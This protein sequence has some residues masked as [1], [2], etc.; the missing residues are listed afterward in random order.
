MAEV[1]NPYNVMSQDERLRQGSNGFALPQDD[2]EIEIAPEENSKYEEGVR[3]TE[4]EDGSVLIDLSPRPDFVPSDDFDANLAEEL[5]DST[6]TQIASQLLEGIRR[7]DDSRQEWLSNYRNGMEL[8]GLKVKPANADP[9]ASGAPLEGMSNV[10]HP[11]L[12]ENVMAFQAAARGELLP[13]AGPVK[14]RDD[15]PS[16]PP[17]LPLATPPLPVGAPPSP[18]PPGM[19]APSAGPDALNPPSSEMSGPAPIQAG[20]PPPPQMPPMAAPQP[21]EMPR[22]QLA[23]AF[24]K[25]FNHYLT[26]TA[27]EYYPDTDQMFFTV[28]FG[29][30]GIKK[31]INCPIRRRPVSESVPIEDFIVSNALND[32][33]NAQ[34]ITHAI[35]MKPSTLR[36]M[37]LLGVYRNIELGSPVGENNTN[38]VTQLKADISGVKINTN[39]P[40]DAEYNLYETLCELDIPGYEH[41][42]RKGKVTGLKLPYRVVI[43]KESEKIL[44]IRRNWKEDDP[45]CIAK[46]YYAEYYYDKAF[47]FYGI[48]L[49]NLLGNTTKALTAVW[50]EFIDSGMF[51]NF[52]GM[53][54]NKGLGRQMTNQF[55]VPPG[56]GIGLD[57]GLQSI[58]DAIM[59]LPYKDLGPAFAAFIQRVEELG[60][61]LGGT[62]NMNVAEGKQDAPVGTT[63]ALIEQQTKAIGAVMKRLHASQAREFALLKERFRDDPSAFWRFNPRPARKWDKEAF[64][65]ALNDYDLVPV[66]DPNNPTAMHRSAKA[67]AIAQY[68]MTAPGVLDPKKVWLRVAR[69][70]EV[71]SPEDLLMP[72]PPPGA[73]PPPDPTKMAELQVKTSIEGM[74]QQNTMTKHQTDAQFKA[75]ELQDREREREHEMQLAI[76]AQN[77]EKLRLASN[78]AM[79]ADKTEAAERALQ[80][81]F[82][83]Q[84]RSRSHDMEQ[85]DIAAVLER[86]TR[87]EEREHSMDQDMQSRM[88]EEQRTAEEREHAAQQAQADREHA[89]QLEKIRA[90]A[91]KAS[92]A[93]PKPKAAKKKAKK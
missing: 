6:L 32:L 86:L 83:D 63:L 9:G 24:E 43:E 13:A 72:P 52:P 39:D 19:G 26:S 22:D 75:A 45:L 37:Q 71:D 17:P 81:K 40:E 42:D 30:S 3:R 90:Q 84:E 20:V 89:L 77:T 15:M 65:K 57:V 91:K 27:K 79:H 78:I 23:A 73:M 87:H 54:F 35:T 1:T 5:D 66:S 93:K 25:D 60:M 41:K 55:R 62:A 10:D 31:V 67:M 8:L 49:L 64:I 47:G 68:Q 44:E 88:V 28:G 58:R 21:I 61:R 69:Q 16:M 70:I 14:I 53:I 46:E 74:K 56:G 38:P 50:R 51:S 82:Q 2:I 76:I 4:L 29:G 12:L 92:A 34:R 80:Y 7:D 59:P 11:L 33:G 48:G 36:R 18:V 85:N